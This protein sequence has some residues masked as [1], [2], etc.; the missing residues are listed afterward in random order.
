MIRPAT[1]RPLRPGQ[2]L[3]LMAWRSL[4][5]VGRLISRLR[6]LSPPGSITNHSYGSHPDERIELIEP[7]AGAQSRA[8]VVYVHGGG[9]ICGKKEIYTR[10]L[11]FLA[12]AGYPVFNVEYPLAPERP[13]P[14]ML[15][16]LLECLAWIR[17]QKP[18]HES[19]HLMGDSA[20]GNLVLMLAILTENPTLIRTL[21]PDFSRVLPRTQSVISIYGVLDRLSW[22]E[23]GFPSASLMLECYAGPEALKPE[24][25]PDSAVTPMDVEFDA[26]PPTLIAVGDKDQLAESSRICAE[27]LRKRFEPVEYEVYPGEAHGFFNRAGRPACQKLRGDILGFF[28]KH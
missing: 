20:G 6:R 23:K 5:G 9:W 3:G 11:L 24:I 26:L 28:E 13:H 7:R 8:P 22:I 1:A 27:Q 2:R 12:E 4:M 25:G 21:D 10:E 14:H 19:V 15:L 18:E 16:S 17:Q